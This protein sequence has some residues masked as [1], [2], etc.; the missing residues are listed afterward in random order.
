MGY[1]HYWTV[2]KT[3]DLP[4]R[5][6]LAADVAEL[7]D[8]LG[9]DVAFEFD[10]PSTRPVVSADMI[11]FNGI[12]EAGHETFML[13]WTDPRGDFCKT[14]R[15]PYD[16]LVAATLLLARY[17]TAGQQAFS[18]SS[19]GESADF[20]EARRRIDQI[21]DIEIEDLTFLND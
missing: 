11:R 17:Y 6:R 1:T 10:K 16:L 21:L 4:A 14:A 3:P 20:E 2:T 15:K 12:G 13:D 19:D 7:I 9:I 5:Q 18:F 8:R